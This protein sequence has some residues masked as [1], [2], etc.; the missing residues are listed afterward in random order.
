MSLSEADD[1]GRNAS[2]IRVV[3]N[4]LLTHQL[5]DN[6]KLLIEVSSSGQKGC[7]TGGRESVLVILCLK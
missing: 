6:Q 3:K 1:A 2:A 4:V 5:A 7:T